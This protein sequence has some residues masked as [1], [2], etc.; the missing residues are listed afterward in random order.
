MA[1][2]VRVA[3]SWTCHLC[4][5]RVVEYTPNARF[6]SG[7]LRR[8]RGKP[9]PLYVYA[10]APRILAFTL[11]NTAGPDAPP[12]ARGK[13]VKRV[14]IPAQEIVRRQGEDEICDRTGNEIR[15]ESN[16]F[17]RTIEQCA[18]LRGR[19]P[20]IVDRLWLF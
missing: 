8:V 3:T 11:G 5:P 7:C 17:N 12:M 14:R 1:T 19:I 10:G 9:R 6:C 4:P 18:H 2:L 20:H 13:R 15:A 16:L